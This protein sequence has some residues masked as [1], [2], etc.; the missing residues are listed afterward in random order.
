MALARFGKFALRAKRFE[1][2]R[3]ALSAKSD[4]NSG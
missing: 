2:D 1:F 4:M 3:R